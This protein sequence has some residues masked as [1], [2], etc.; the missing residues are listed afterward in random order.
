MDRSSLHGIFTSVNRQNVGISK[1]SKIIFEK[2]RSQF[3]TRAQSDKK[4]I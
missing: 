1:S 2:E 3:M 4:E